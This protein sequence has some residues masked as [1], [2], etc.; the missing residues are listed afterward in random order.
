[1]SHAASGTFETNP[2]AEERRKWGCSKGKKHWSAFEIVAMVLGFVIFWPLGLLA[3]F[4]K[5]KNGEMWAGASQGKRH[6]PGGKCHPRIPGARQVMALPRQAMPPSM[7]TS[8]RNWR[9]LKKS[10]AN[11]MM[12]KK[13]SA[14]TWRAFA[15]R[16]TRTSST[17]LWRSGMRRRRANRPQPND[18]SPERN[19]RAFIFSSLT[20]HRAHLRPQASI[21]PRRKKCRTVISSQ[22]PIRHIIAERVS[23]RGFLLG[24]GPRW[25]RLRRRVLSARCFPA[26]P[27]RR[28][29]P[30]AWGSPSLPASTMTSTGWPMAMTPGPGRLGDPMRAGDAVI[31]V[32][33]LDAAT[34]AQ[35]FG[36]NCDY[37]AFMPLPTAR[38]VPTTGCSASTTNIPRPTSC[39]PA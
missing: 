21:S 8:A 25:A 27:T 28:T 9:A 11:L 10:G 26:P 17:A 6:G 38:R 20:C 22:P 35:R 19:F 34:Q 2:G 23:R 37:V 24:S 16:K 12:S 32:A 1:M 3:L 15:K 36:Y 31:D 5:L 7:I 29:P 30:R 13:L 33:T 14:I 4:L 18:K 39:L